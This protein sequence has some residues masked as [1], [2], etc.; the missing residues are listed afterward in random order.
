MIQS[1][2][3]LKENLKEQG[4]TESNLLNKISSHLELNARDITSPSRKRELVEARVIYSVLRK[5]QNATHEEIADELNR[6]YTAIV[7]YLKNHD[8]WMISDK[9]Y[10]YKF[11]GIKNKL[12]KS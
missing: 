1:L 10:Y 8:N 6:Q 2:Q 11:Y 7:W 9:E 4:L 12:C 5:Q 3:Q